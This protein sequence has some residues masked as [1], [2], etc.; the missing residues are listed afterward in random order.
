MHHDT[1]WNGSI[2]TSAAGMRSATTS[3][4]QRAPSAVTTSTAAARSSQ[5]SSANA[6][7]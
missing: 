1:A 4:I 6:S 2:A 5:S 3:A 7:S